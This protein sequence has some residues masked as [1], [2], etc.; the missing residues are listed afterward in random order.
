M[1]KWFPPWTVSQDTW[2]EALKATV[3]G[4]STDALLFSQCRTPLI[5]R[6]RVLGRGRAHTSLRGSY[7]SQLRAF[8]VQAD[9]DGRLAHKRNSEKLSSL[10]EGPDPQRGVRRRELEDV[11]PRCKSRRALSPL[12]RR[13]KTVSNTTTSSVTV[14]S[15]APHLCLC[16]GRPLRLRLIFV[17]RILL[18]RISFRPDFSLC[19]SR[20]R[21]IRLLRSLRLPSLCVSILIL[22]RSGI[23]RWVPTVLLAQIRS[24]GG[25]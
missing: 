23:L 12:Q 10:Q 4:V 8:T 3:S 9:S 11:L 19:G 7:M 16:G 21:S 15:P 18:T 13:T 1:G 5:Y 20:R 17:C 25:E 6:Y 22:S 14:S 2:H 24:L